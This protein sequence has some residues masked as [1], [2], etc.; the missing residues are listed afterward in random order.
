MQGYLFTFFTQK[1]REHEG[2]PLADWIVEQ[3][4]KIGVR[5]ATLFSGKEGFGHDGRFHS[6]NYFDFEDPP[7]LV[8]MALSENECDRLMAAMQAAEVNIFYTKSKAEF[9]FTFDG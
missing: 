1:T 7:Q 3:A 4:K 8:T 2:I 9:G 5:G 6:G